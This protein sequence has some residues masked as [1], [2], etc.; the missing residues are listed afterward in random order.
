MNKLLLGF[1][2]TLSAGI[3]NAGQV[4]GS[5]GS[6]KEL[7]KLQDAAL[8][9]ELYSGAVGGGGTSGLTDEEQKVFSSGLDSV[10][11]TFLETQENLL[12]SDEK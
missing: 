9:L 8:L 3:A 12:C 11:F 6:G 2:I 10:G 1:I 4:G 7:S 5:G